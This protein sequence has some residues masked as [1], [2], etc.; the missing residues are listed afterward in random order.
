MEEDNWLAFVLADQHTVRFIADG[1]EM[2]SSLK[3]APQEETGSLQTE[4]HEESVGELSKSAHCS[5]EV[6]MA[7]TSQSQNQDQ[8]EQAQNMNGTM[9]KPA[10]DITYEPGRVPSSK[11]PIRMHVGF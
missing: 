11:F 4:K 6:P 7:G 3:G 9:Q 5:Q 8:T 1:Q 2:I 10:K